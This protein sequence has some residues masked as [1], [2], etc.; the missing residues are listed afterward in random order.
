MDDI[1]VILNRSE[2]DIL[3]LGE[4]FLDNDTLDA[5][6]NIDGYNFYRQDRTAASGKSTG[7][8]LIIYFKEGRDITLLTNGLHCTPDLECMWIELC[9]TQAK[10][11][12]IGNIYRAPDSKVQN[13][14]DQL[15]DIMSKIGVGATVDTVILGDINIDVLKN[16]GNTRN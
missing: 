3:C 14:L 1:R 16:T 2:L 11:T 10:K 8:G 12:L 15:E 4:T 5:E 7:G 13:G 9:L 6:L